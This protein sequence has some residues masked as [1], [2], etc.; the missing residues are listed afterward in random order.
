MGPQRNLGGYRYWTLCV[1]LSQSW[2]ADSRSPARHRMVIEQTE[3][4]RGVAIACSRPRRIF[5]EYGTMHWVV[6]SGGAPTDRRVANGANHCAEKNQIADAAWKAGAIRRRGEA[7][8]LR[9]T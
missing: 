8:L 6:S 4:R 9:K 5:N 1:E 2:Q 7:G 3:R